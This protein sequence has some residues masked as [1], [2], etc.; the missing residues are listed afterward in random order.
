METFARTATTSS[1]PFSPATTQATMRTYS[2]DYANHPRTTPYITARQRA[3]RQAREWD[4]RI[5]VNLF[6]SPRDIQDSLQLELPGLDYVLIGGVELPDPFTKEKNHR[7]E[8]VRANGGSVSENEHVHIA[9]VFKQPVNRE[10]ALRACRP[11]KLTDEYAVPR[12]SKFT[13]AGWLAHHAKAVYKLDPNMPTIFYEYGTLPE[14]DITDEKVCWSVLK[15]L[16]KFGTKDVKARFAAYYEAIDGFKAAKRNEV[17][18]AT[19]N[20]ATDESF[21]LPPIPAI[22]K[23]MIVTKADA[24]SL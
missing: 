2:K 21:V 9:L 1:F 24:K 3:E 19:D 7:N 4:I 12:N 15:I 20:A 6:L 18:Q 17:I 8:Q 5:D 23:H 14:D 22:P 13:Y 11:E 16:K 10:R